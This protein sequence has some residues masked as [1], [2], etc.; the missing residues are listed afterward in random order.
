VT[1]ERKLDLI[2]MGRTCVDLY[3][4]QEGS[5]LEDVQSFRKYVGGSSTN[6]AIGTAR[7]GVKVAMLSRVGDE[8]MGRFVREMLDDTGVDVGHLKAE[9]DRLTPYC[10]LAVREVD[11]F[12][13][14]FVYKDSADMPIDEDDVD[15]DFI[16]SSK[17]LLVSGTHFSRASA[18]RATRRAMQAAKDTGTKIVLDIDYRPNFWG[19]ALL[20]K[21]VETT[22]AIK[23]GEA[24]QIVIGYLPGGDLLPSS[25]AARGLRF[26]SGVHRG[27]VAR[28]DRERSRRGHGIGTQGS[29]RSLCNAGLRPILS[30]RHGRAR[31]GMEGEVG[32]GLRMAARVSA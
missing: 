24:H 22:A 7:L 2:C 23:A 28:R 20:E 26:P 10:L 3:G 18:G 27:R 19:K 21:D 31:A 6:I 30:E 29:P 15:P 17:A 5:R 1:E 4:E 11:D 16:A 25:K 14:I 32:S 9:P 8:H 12:P 13:R